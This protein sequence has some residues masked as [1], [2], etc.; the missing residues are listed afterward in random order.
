[1]LKKLPSDKINVAKNAIF[2]LLQAPTHLSFTFNS[3]FLCELKYKARLS[4][5]WVVFSI[6][7]SV[8]FFLEFI[9][10]FNKTHGRFDIKITQFLT[11]LK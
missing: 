1:M 5:I 8:L 7:D 9:F 2:S 10:S 6:F 3:R 4:K 11:K